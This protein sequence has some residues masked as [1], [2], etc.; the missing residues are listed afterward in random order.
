MENNVAIAVWPVVSGSAMGCCAPVGLYLATD[1]R[2]SLP[3]TL[4]RP[5]CAT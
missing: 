1:A 5:R 3:Q 4:I 2:L